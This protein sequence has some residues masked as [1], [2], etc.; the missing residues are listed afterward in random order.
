MKFISDS[1]IANA[2]RYVALDGLRGILAIT[3]VI[4]HYAQLYHLNWMGKAW[5]SVD[6]FFILSGFVITHSYTAK[7]R[8]GMGFFDFVKSRL[9]RLYP[10]YMIGFFLGLAGLLLE[11]HKT[12]ISQLELSFSM[13]SGL[14]IL[15]YFNQIDWPISG[16]L[17]KGTI[18]PLND[19][20]WSLFFELFVNFLFFVWVVRIRR[21]S[22]AAICSVAFFVYLLTAQFVGIHSGWGTSNF[23]G[24]I[25]RVIFYFSLGCIIYSIHRKIP[26]QSI[27]SVAFLTAILIIGFS[28]R[29]TMVAYFLLLIVSPLAI[30]VASRTEI[31]GS[32]LFSG[33]LTRLG[34]MSYPLYITH[35]PLAFFSHWILD[36]AGVGAGVS[37]LTATF[38]AL[39]VSVPLAAIEPT[40]RGRLAALIKPLEK[41]PVA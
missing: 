13:L 11:M 29:N 14:L 19:P 32:P 17:H 9:L 23:V 38:F 26:M 18:F 20:A 41:G 8:S 39:A 34:G 21:V 12:S 31:T 24:G 5:I 7:I 33:I 10:M 36:K 28:L 4:Y 15:P 27:Y 25:P 35:F 2:K 16:V 30:L 3:V 1:K 37:V 22:S 40:L 6:A